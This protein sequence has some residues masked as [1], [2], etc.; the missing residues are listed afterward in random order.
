M[1][2][3][4]EAVG[5]LGREEPWDWMWTMEVK[6]QSRIPAAR[7]PAL[8]ASFQDRIQSPVGVAAAGVAVVEGPTAAVAEEQ[9][10]VVRKILKDIVPDVE[11]WVVPVGS[12]EV[13]ILAA[14]M[15]RVDQTAAV[16]VAAVEGT[17]HAAE[18]NLG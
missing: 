1:C 4:S 12:L 10:A 5:F 16:V 17:G 18:Y 15:A 6:I 13:G 11:T 14:G 2:D 7:D 8:A 3:G 9:V